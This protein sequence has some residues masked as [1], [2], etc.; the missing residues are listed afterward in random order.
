MILIGL[1]WVCVKVTKT[2][3][4]AS[5]RYAAAQANL[6]GDATANVPNAATGGS[7]GT[8]FPAK[9]GELFS[10]NDPGAVPLMQASKA[11]DLPPNFS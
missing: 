8:V 6:T 7:T 4:I 11:A 1:I 9:Q 10:V 3:N 5:A 2:A